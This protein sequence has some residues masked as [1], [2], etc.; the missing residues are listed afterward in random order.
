MLKKISKIFAFIIKTMSEAG[1]LE[2]QAYYI[3]SKNSSK[4]RSKIA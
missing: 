4:T 3:A 2:S 1:K